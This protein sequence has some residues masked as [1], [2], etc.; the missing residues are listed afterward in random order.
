M[1]GSTKAVSHEGAAARRWR[2][3]PSAKIAVGVSVV[4]LLAGGV[5]AAM[6]SSNTTDVAITP[7]TPVRAVSSGATVAAGKVYSFVASGGSTTVP[8]NATVVQLA[9]TVKGS[10]AGTV[11]F[12]PLGDAAQESTDQVSWSAGG[13]NTGTVRVNVGQGNKV[14]VTNTSTATAVVGIKITGYSTQITAAS[15]ASAGGQP[16]QVLSIDNANKVKWLDPTST[17]G[18]PIDPA[19][20]SEEGGADGS[21]L[22]QLDG[23][24][25]GWVKPEKSTVRAAIKM[26]GA[27]AGTASVVPGSDAIAVTNTTV[28]NY[29]VY[30]ARNLTGCVATASPGGIAPSVGNGKVLASLYL[31]VFTNGVVVTAN[32]PNAG[33]APE[34]ANTSFMIV[35]NC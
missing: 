4:A 25:V 32:V 31:T 3:R 11:K 17:S 2:V 33:G 5:T 30:F 19:Q 24:G 29:T 18:D 6:A 35:V 13:N 1:R 23:G 8:S 9:I 34:P 22:T 10:K 28:G 26:T 27:G 20:I 7:L 16:G 15:I 21:V 12:G 14:A